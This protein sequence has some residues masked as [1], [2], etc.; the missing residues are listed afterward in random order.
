MGRLLLV[1]S[2]A[3]TLTA[4]GAV[5]SAD[6]AVYDLAYRLDTEEQ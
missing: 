6:I 1:A 5:V 4:L 3:A 2:L